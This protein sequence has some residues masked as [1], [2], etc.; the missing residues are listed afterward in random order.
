MNNWIK[1]SDRIPE[2]RDD[3][4][5]VYFADND[6]IDMVHIHDYFKDITAGKIDGVQQYTKWYKS[7]KVTHWMEL[8]DRPE[9]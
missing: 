5:L 4:V 9:E 8:P 6:S 2:I 1:C 7:Q 3:S